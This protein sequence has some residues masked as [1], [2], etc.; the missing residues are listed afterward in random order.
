[1]APAPPIMAS[2]RASPTDT[3]IG[4]AV[5]GSDTGS[6]ET[7]VLK[8]ITTEQVAKISGDKEPTVKLSSRPSTAPP[9]SQTQIIMSS[10]LLLDDDIPSQA[11]AASV[12]PGSDAKAEVKGVKKHGNEIFLDETIALTNLRPVYPV[13]RR[14]LQE[15]V[16]P[17]IISDVIPKSG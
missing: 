3:A 5:S 17:S 12:E 7:M 8:N 10:K 16:H 6:S 4:T 9:A 11:M 15:L 1:M 13:S 2:D 14:A